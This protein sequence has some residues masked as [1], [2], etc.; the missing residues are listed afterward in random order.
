MV[1]TA[2]LLRIFHSNSNTP[3]GY[4]CSIDPLVIGKDVSYQHLRGFGCLAYMHVPKDHRSKLDSKSKAC[5]FMG[6]SGHEFGYRLW[7]LVN[8][9]VLRSRDIVFLED[10]TIEDWKQQK[11]EPT[12]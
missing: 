8:K 7:D 9:K 10:K 4:I 2:F 11:L 12:P 5:I 6:Y 3:S 1:A